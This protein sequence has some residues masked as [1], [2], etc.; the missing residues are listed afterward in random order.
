MAGFRLSKPYTMPREELREA[1]E[2]LAE[3]LT[4]DHGM[5]CRWQGDC[6]RLSGAGFDGELDMHGET[7]D[8]S[9]KLGLLTSVF[10]DMLRSEVQRYLDEHIY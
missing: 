8:V 5:R 4:R 2:G 6:V 3:Q 10:K 1:A 7:V 9:V